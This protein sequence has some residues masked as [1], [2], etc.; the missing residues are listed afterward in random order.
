MI[1]LALA[2]GIGVLGA[3]ATASVDATLEDALGAD[4]VVTSTSFQPFSPEVA[5]AIGQVDGVG[6]VS[7]VSLGPALIGGEET[8]VTAV[9]P[10][11]T[12]AFS[13]DVSSG[14]LA[15][16]TRG[17]V[18]VDTETAAAA[19]VGMFDTV[20]VLWAG[21]PARL[22][23]VG[24][25]EPAGQFSGWVV[26]RGAFLEA[27]NLD[28]DFGLY[29]LLDDGAD[30]AAVRVDLDEALAAFPVVQ[31]QDQ[32][33]FAASVRAQV[34]QLLGLIY[35]LLAL[36][37]VIAVLGIVNTLAL[38][39]LERTREIGLLR[40]VGTRRRQVRAMIRRESVLIAVF[41]GVLGV[42][43]GIAFGVAIQR[44][45]VEDGISVLAV[46]WTL[47]GVVLVVSA[48]VGLVAAVLPAWRASRLDILS[49]I[50]TD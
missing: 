18:V 9:Q 26:D 31:L 25:F 29:V 4:Y 41:G 37:V 39:V 38:S 50:A 17:T 13:I 2:T 14:S 21:G 32:T 49:A 30:P 16:L 3:S 34:N 43:L 45:L 27:G 20:D 10:S 47:I 28:Q 5:R 11:I 19:G 1:G 36:A 40:A 7:R 12:E 33:E 46:P 35:G 42:G 6:T 22:Q 15:D 44:S 48:V 24:L 23:V 8:L